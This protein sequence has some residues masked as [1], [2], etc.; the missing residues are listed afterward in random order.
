M[1]PITDDDVDR[2]ATCIR[3]VADQSQLMFHIF[4]DM[5]R[6]SLSVM[7]SVK[8]E[9]EREFQKVSCARRPSGFSVHFYVCYLMIK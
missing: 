6:Q 2:I 3:I 9:E 5:C 4:N 7:L 1:Q 8:A